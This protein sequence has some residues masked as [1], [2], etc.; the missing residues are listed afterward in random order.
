MI[1]RRDLAWWEETAPTLR[2]RFASTM[3]EWPHSYIVRGGGSRLSD[4]DFT[5][6]VRVIRTFG[7]PGKFYGKT[8]IYLAIN[9]TKWWAMDGGPDECEIINQ[10]ES[11]QSYGDQDAPTTE[12]GRFIVYDSLATEYDARY[13]E[14]EDLAENKHVQDLV[15]THFGPTAPSTLDVGC[16]TGLLL[17]L[18]ITAPGVYTAV[19]PSKGMLNEL[20]RKHPKV[21]DVVPSTM[22]EAIGFFKPRQ[23]DLVCALFGSPSYISPEVL[24]QIPDLS[25][26]LTIFMH[27]K[28]GY[29]PDYWTERPV[30]DHVDSSREAARMIPGATT[31][32]LNNFDVTVVARYGAY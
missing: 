9:G 23:F 29:L 11:S 32:R 26:D 14:A 18:G 24:V 12:A 10:A 6:A 17:D 27:Y 28:E 25:S 13:D 15:R 3:P 31:Y 2:W 8:R 30:P 21:R 22:E 5:R 16:G 4:E 7:D 20:L 1:S 19:D